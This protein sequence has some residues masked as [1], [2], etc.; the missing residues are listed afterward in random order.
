MEKQK[1]ILIFCAKFNPPTNSHILIVKKVIKKINPDKI[2]IAIDRHKTIT[3]NEIF[4]PFFYHKQMIKNLIVENKIKIEQIDF[5]ENFNKL[6]ILEHKNNKIY[7]LVDIN[8]HE[9]FKKKKNFAKI[10]QFSKFIY[11]RYNK[12][13]LKIFDHV[14]NNFARNSYHIDDKKNFIVS[15]KRMLGKTNACYIRKNHLYLEYMIKN[16]LPKSRYLHTL[17]VLSTATKIGYGNN[18]NDKQILQLQIAAI[19]HDI[20]KMY[21]DKQIKKI[22]SNKQLMSFP[23]IHCAHGLI[24]MKIAKNR[25]KI[26]D[27]IILNAIANHVICKDNNKITK[28]LFCADKLEPAR[29]KK[30]IPHRYQLYHQCINNNLNNVFQKV[31][32]LNRKK[33]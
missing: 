7:F 24:G 9:W 16:K 4:P 6:N 32:K 33:Y 18:F 12:E 15:N 25:Y 2:F 14:K 1:T 11:Y 27:K 8:K 28:A 30:D 22:L 21:S 19:L 17:R 31:L 5:V 13:V 3:N 10:K 29:T 26:N 23:T 20:G